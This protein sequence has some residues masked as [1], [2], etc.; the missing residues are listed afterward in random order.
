MLSPMLVTALQG[1]ISYKPL[2]LGDNKGQPFP[3]HFQKE[4]AC[5][6]SPDRL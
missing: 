2:W 3:V 6:S 5:I 4:K 1:A